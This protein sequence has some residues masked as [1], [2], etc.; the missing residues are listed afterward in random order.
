MART[1]SREAALERRKALTNGGKKASAQ[2]MSSPGRVRTA[3][4]AQ[5]SRT[6]A[7]SAAPAAPAPVPA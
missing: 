2:F 7:V 5:R 3:A 6:E 1:T 4:D